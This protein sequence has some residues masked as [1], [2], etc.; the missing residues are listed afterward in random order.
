MK[1]KEEVKIRE[2]GFDYYKRHIH[3][4]NYDEE[5]E[6]YGVISKQI[7]KL[8]KKNNGH[9]RGKT[10]WFDSVGNQNWKECE[11]L[12]YDENEKLFSIKIITMKE[13]L[14]SADENVPIT[15][16]KKVTRFNCLMEGE[17]MKNLNR[18]VKLAQNWYF[19]AEKYMALYFF[20][21]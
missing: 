7:E 1:K 17:S 12:S 10:K 15:I 9:I 19:Y 3:L 11:V 13:Q 21:C 16:Y 18:R 14:T 4:E 8:K 20:F 6:S 5:P 2:K